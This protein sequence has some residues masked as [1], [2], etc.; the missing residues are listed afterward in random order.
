[1]SSR[2]SFGWGMS[3]STWLARDKIDKSYV[4]VKILTSHHTK[5]CPNKVAFGNF[6]VFER[7]S[8]PPSTPHCL[9]LMSHFTVPGKLEGQHLCLVTKDPRW[10]PKR[11]LLHLL[12]GIAHIH[13]R[14]I[15]HTDLKHDNI[16]FDTPLSTDDFDKLLA[17]DPSRRHASH[18]GSVQAAV[19]QPL[20]IPTLQDAMKQNFLV[21]DFGSAQPIF[22]H[23]ENEIS[24]LPLRPPK[25][26][27]GGPWN[28]K[29]DIW[30]FGCLIF[31]LITGRALF[32]YQADP[33]YNL[34]EPNFMLYQMICY[35]C[36][37]FRVEQLSVSPLA[38]Q[39]FDS[40]CNLK[41]NP[42]LFDYP[43]EISIRSYKVIEEADVLS[44]AAFMRRCLRLDPEKRASWFDGVE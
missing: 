39:F 36:E 12:R 4:A 32:K 23:T 41:A 20:P 10:R 8:R 40:T 35:T 29:V 6:E 15:V 3:S 11:I 28:A 17:S 37:D 5:L 25:I 13:S 18:D 27:I 21:G 7:V 44:T 31:E 30:A 1:M 2:E 33:K 26:M 34:D 14:G 22:I 43:F 19:S 42:P 16:F 9:G 24:A 38:A